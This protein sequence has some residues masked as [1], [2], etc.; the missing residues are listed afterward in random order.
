VASIKEAQ[1]IIA[2]ELDETETLLH[3]LLVTIPNLPCDMVPEGKT[4]ADNVVEK[5]GG[6]MPELGDDAL[7]HWE[8]AKKIQPHR[9]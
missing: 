6:P 1:R 2:A 7:P 4:A 8:L 5:T 9:F 3:D